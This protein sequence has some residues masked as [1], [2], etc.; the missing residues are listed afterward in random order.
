M[1]DLPSTIR[2]LLNPIARRVQTMIARAVIETLSDAGSR[3]VVQISMQAD[4]LRDSVERFQEYG[5]SGVPSV[6][7]EAIAL[8]VGGDGDHPVVIVVE[9]R[10]CRPTGMSEGEVCVYTKQNAKRVYC[11]K[12]GSIEIGTSPTDFAALASKVNSELTKI[13][14]AFS[15]FVPGTGGA[16][17]GSPYTTAGNVSASEV[18]IK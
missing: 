2:K 10:S 8:L 13:A 6:G 7:A 1:I 17:F 4:S 12:D 9:D 18:K 15:S 5:F 16:S 3:Q 11:K 14:T